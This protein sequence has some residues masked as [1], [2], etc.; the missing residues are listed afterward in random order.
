ML[1][2]QLLLADRQRSL[3]QRLGLVRTSPGSIQSGQ[4]V[5]AQGRIGV[6]WT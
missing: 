4:V 5:E 3:V 2:T 1:G 6:L